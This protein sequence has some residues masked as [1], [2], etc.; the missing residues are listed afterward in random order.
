MLKKINNIIVGENAIWL[1]AIEDGIKQIV[2]IYS[3]KSDLHSKNE[4]VIVMDIFKFAIEN[5]Y[6]FNDKN[7]ITKPYFLTIKNINKQIEKKQD[8]IDSDLLYYEF[9][10][11][12]AELQQQFYNIKQYLYENVEIKLDKNGKADKIE[13]VYVTVEFKKVREKFK[14]P[15]K[16]NIDEF[17]KAIRE[18]NDEICNCRYVISD[19]GK[20]YIVLANE[21]ELE[22]DKALQRMKNNNASEYL[23]LISARNQCFSKYTCISDIFFINHNFCIEDT[24]SECLNYN[25]RKDL[26][27]YLQ[28]TEVIDRICNL[29]KEDEEEI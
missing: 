1:K 18:I 20:R 19:D 23:K 2:G 21:N 24:F 3:R 29:K 4:K 22:D 10:N 6:E 17:R 8:S 27:E 7:S 26:I 14:E 28:Q 12:I 5:N 9:R 11:S 16:I 13:G 25:I 15:I